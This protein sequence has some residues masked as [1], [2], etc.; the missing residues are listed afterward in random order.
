MVL[1]LGEGE[2]FLGELYITLNLLV[3]LASYPK[4]KNMQ[5]A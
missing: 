2:G 3:E 5:G 4:K 1:V